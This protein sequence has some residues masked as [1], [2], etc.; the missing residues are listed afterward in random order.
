MQCHLIRHCRPDM[1]YPSY[2][3]DIRHHVKK[4]AHCWLHCAALTHI[5]ALLM[6]VGQQLWGKESSTR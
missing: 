4:R 5:H 1:A 2:Q 6:Q 3:L